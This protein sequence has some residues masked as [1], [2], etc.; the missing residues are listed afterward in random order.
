VG[1][2]RKGGITR[3]ASWG[4]GWEGF[5]PFDERNHAFGWLVLQEGGSAG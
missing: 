2:R 3:Y 1:G 5:T 4:E